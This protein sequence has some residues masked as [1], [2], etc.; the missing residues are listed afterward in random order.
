MDVSCG[1]LQALFHTKG[2]CP[3]P[4]GEDETPRPTM[5][6]GVFL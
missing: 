1:T 6:P 3:D 5:T 2:F 4:R